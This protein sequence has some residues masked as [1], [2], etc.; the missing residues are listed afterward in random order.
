M[1]L[2]DNILSFT[3]PTVMIIL[4]YGEDALRVKERVE[5]MKKKFVEKFDPAGMNLDEFAFPGA[6]GDKSTVVGA[7]QASPFLGDKRMVVIRGLVSSLKKTDNTFWLPVFPTIPAS[8]IAIFADIAEISKLQKTEA[9]KTLAALNDVHL[10]P[11]L[12]L[13]GRELTL[14]VTSRAKEYGANI[15]SAL[16]ARLLAR[17][18]NDSWRVDAELRKLSAYAN[19]APITEA[20][21]GELV[22]RDVEENIF[23]FL[24]TLSANNPKQTLAKLADERHAGAGD[25][26]LFGML[27]RQIRLLLQVRNLMTERIGVTKADVADAL[28]MHPFVAQKILAESRKWSPDRLKKLHN[29]AFDL[30]RA[31]KTGLDPQIAVDR[32]VSAMLLHRAA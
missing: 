12:P 17:V 3:M 32:L 29:L 2:L 15:S 5:D 28:G 18:A 24:D 21:I 14:W 20:M 25:F 8:T 11:L 13:E 31:A 6:E 23:A 9:H 26:Q 7:L 1:T 22:A 10:Y 27:V 16:L 4:I 30:D 19:G